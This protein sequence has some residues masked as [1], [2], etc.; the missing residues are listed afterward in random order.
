MDVIKQYTTWADNKHMRSVVVKEL[1]VKFYVQPDQFTSLYNAILPDA[2]GTLEQILN[3]V[4]DIDR[5]VGKRQVTERREILYLL[6]V[7]SSEKDVRKAKEQ[8]KHGTTGNLKWQIAFATET[9]ITTFNVETASSIRLKLRSSLIR[10]EFPDWRFDFTIVKTVQRAQFSQIKTII[11]KYFTKTVTVKNFIDQVPDTAHDMSVEFEIEY[12]GTSTNA[13]NIF[14]QF[15]SLVDFVKFDP[16]AAANTGMQLI[17]GKIAELIVPDKAFAKSFYGKNTLKQLANQ[18]KV[19]DYQIYRNLVVP[20]IE[21]FYLSDK[22]DGNR[23]FMAVFP[24]SDSVHYVSSTLET[25][26]LTKGKVDAVM[27]LD[28][29]KLPD[30]SLAFDIVYWDETLTHLEFGQRLE[31]LEA[32]CKLLSKAG[33]AIEVKQQIKL[34]SHYQTEIKKMFEKKRT[35]PIDG[36]IFTPDKTIGNEKLFKN[37][38]HYF[39]MVVYKYKLPENQTIDFLAM[40]A[41]KSVLG[42]E[43]YELRNGFELMFLFCGVS[44]SQF[45]SLGLTEPRGYDEIFANLNISAQYFPAAFMPSSNPLAYLWW[46][47]TKDAQSVAGH[48]VE[49]LYKDGWTLHKVRL[50]R[51]GQVARGIGYGNSWK[52]AELTFDSYRDP[53]T[54]DRLINPTTADAY[55]A[56][57]KSDRYKP[58]TRF[59]AYVKAQV[60][61]QLEG[62]DFLIDLAAGKGQDLFTIHGFGIKNV[63]F[64]DRD[65]EALVELVSR[66]YHLG[67][68]KWYM[69][70]FKPAKSMN[71]MTTDVD[72]TIDTANIIEALAV[73][74]IKPGTADGI[75]MNFAIHYIIKDATSLQNLINVVDYYCKPGGLFIFTCFDGKRVFDFLSRV[76]H[77]KSLD[78]FDPDDAEPD[79][80]K[81]S[82]RKDYS[83]NVFKQTGLEVGVIH[84]F[85]D[86]EY[87]VESL[88][89]LEWIMD[90][91]KKLGYTVL[92]N[93][94][95][96][97]WL[98][99]YSSFDKRIKLSE[100]DQI[101]VSLYSY[102]TV[103]KPL[104]SPSVK[105]A[106]Q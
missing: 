8:F 46:C 70:G 10:N 6:G 39:D 74:N 62:V 55:F 12:I 83:D 5:A 81:Y 106:K 26:A 84:P 19:L 64:V 99:K 91:F 15:N 93:S 80:V 52:T 76:K 63:L 66:K 1:E 77:G 54:F 13:E 82:I 4:T 41:P 101:Y 11:S 16:A 17:L 59:N 25:V 65:K 7:K 44:F 104:K 37:Y 58:M 31:R 20:N 96:G 61:R 60:L 85:S 100:Q 30:R 71:I 67:D 18:P 72:L 43:P 48:V 29:E 14:E 105:P 87:Y 95:F 45:R 53:F 9:A 50:D 75:V 28:V 34:T 79:L 56:K 49:L 57:V 92:Q 69:F 51:D 97:D 88:L 27:I 33:I 24:D 21:D 103:A 32:A 68:K 3:T 35:Y 102:C 36:V 94:S 78:M 89:G 2:T 73:H 98:D 86:G 40:P 42:I 22:A 23:C 38:N 47:P 90:G